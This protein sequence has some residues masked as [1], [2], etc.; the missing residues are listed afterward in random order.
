[1]LI[2]ISITKLAARLPFDKF[3]RT[4]AVKRFLKL[5]VLNKLFGILLLTGI[6][7]GFHFA[8]FRLSRYQRI[9]KVHA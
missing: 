8:Y 3:I 1:M 9:K 7:S 5:F 6:K 4:I 2:S